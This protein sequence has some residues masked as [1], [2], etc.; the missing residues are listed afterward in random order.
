MR[1]V[2][3]IENIKRNQILKLK[4]TVNEMKRI[5]KRLRRRISHKMKSKNFEITQ[6]R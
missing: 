1:N 6:S 2:A 3:G 4:N 5:I